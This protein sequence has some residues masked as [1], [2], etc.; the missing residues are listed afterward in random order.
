MPPQDAGQPARKG[1]RYGYGRVSK[2]DQHTEAQRDA[3]I[4]AGCDPDHLFIEKISSR[5]EKRPRLEEALAYL[6]PGD[7]LVITKLDRLGRSV[8]D[9]IDLVARIEKLGVDL[10]V[11]HQ[12]IDTST[13]AG[14]AFFQM[15]AV[16]AEFERAMIRE[17]TLDGLE[18]AL[19]GKGH[20]G[21]RKRK[22]N[23]R[24]IALLYERYDTLIPV[25]GD[26]PGPGEKPRMMRKY[27][28]AEIAEELGIHRITVYAY[29]RERAQVVT[30]DRRTR[31]GGPALKALAPDAAP[32]RQQTAILVTLRNAE[33]PL[34]S[35]DILPARG[36][37]ARTVTLSRM[38]EAGWIARNERDEWSI[39]P[40]GLKALGR[41][42][43]EALTEGAAR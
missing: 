12:H 35:G 38:E 7:T 39:Q 15:V 17:R 28:S 33:H 19:L 23:D 27:T 36:T 21:G 18:A 43:A 30:G 31:A 20:T 5:V 6:R 10:I 8:T 22:L 9:L 34:L 25:P 42:R 26:D 41:W 3:L 11:L 4:E 14:R 29:L 37:P 16:F 13:A 1:G 24:Q 2:R 32:T 40:D